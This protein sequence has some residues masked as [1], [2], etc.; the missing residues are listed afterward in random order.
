MIHASKLTKQVEA[1][2]RD[3]HKIKRL[4]KR[5]KEVAQGIVEVIV[6]NEEPC[7]WKKVVKKYVQNPTDQNEERVT[8]IR[9]VAHEHQLDYYLA[10]ILFAS[11]CKEEKPDESK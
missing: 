2:L 6:A 3:F 5:Q 9:D 4:S 11:K 1:G 7:D 8:K 10:S